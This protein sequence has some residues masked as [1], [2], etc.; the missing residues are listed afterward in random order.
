MQ[1][2]LTP[3]NTAEHPYFA[4]IVSVGLLFVLPHF[5]GIAVMTAASSVLSFQ[6]HQSPDRF[7][8]RKGSLKTAKCLIAAMWIGTALITA[9]ILTGAVAN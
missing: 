2:H 9:M 8:D 7:R 1:Q 6:V 5:G 3:R 4:L